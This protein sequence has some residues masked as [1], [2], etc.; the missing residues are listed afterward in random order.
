MIHLNS[1][2]TPRM[3]TSIIRHSLEQ[4]VGIILLLALMGIFWVSSVDAAQQLQ[5]DFTELSIE[6]LMNLD[7]DIVSGASKYAQKVTEAPSS[8][9]IVTADEIRKYGY[10]TLADILRSVRSFYTTY[11]RNYHYVGIRGFGRPGDYNVRLLLLLDGHRI[12]DNLDDSASIGT[13]FAIDVDLIDRVEVIRG[14]SSSLYGANAFF[15]VINIV[16]KRGQKLSGLETAAEAASFGKYKGRLSYGDKFRNGLEMILSGSIYD[17]KGQD[18]YFKEF[19]DPAT[20]NGVAENCDDDQYRSFF[21]RLSC[22]D[23][24]LQGGYVSREKGIP[25][26]S[27]ESE[28]NDPR[29]RTVDGQAYVSLKYKHR[30]NNQLAVMARL[31]YNHYNY[32]GDYVFDYSEDDVPYILVNK[33]VGRGKC[34]GGELKLTKNLM[35]KHRFVLGAEYRDNIQQDQSNYDEKVYLDDKR[36]A[37][38]WALYVQDEFQILHSLIFNAGLRYD[39]YDTFGGT[40][41][42]RLGLIYAPIEKTSLKLLYGQAF[43]APNVY[44]LYYDDGEDTQKANPDLEPE[45]IKTYEL[46]VEQYIGTHFRGSVAGF[47]YEIDDLIGQHTDPTDDLLV[48]KNLEEIEAKG[49]ELELEGKWDSGLK[50]RVS[51]TFQKAEDRQTGDVLSNSP[52]HL[53]KFSVGVPLIKEKLFAGMEAQY[54]STRRTL[55]D[56]D[57]D[58]FW[59]TNLTLSSTKLVKGLEVSASVY[60]LFDKRYGDPGSGEHLQDVIEQDGRSVR[61]QLTYGFRP[62][63]AY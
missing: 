23:F 50:G 6:E 57:A 26:A 47:Y 55:A 30:F 4:A 41:N 7:I 39:H 25:T 36:D 54:M 43:R 8:V 48:F 15:G 52:K 10:R 3:R 58:A 24:I 22:R 53:A 2:G 19:D 33:D 46:I 44:E 29:N 12:N 61:I 14:P 11:D 9:S 59:L 37:K 32:D 31:S 49:L 56:K 27:F 38:N 13:E 60:N 21:G 16:T 63:P 5:P 17:S 20:N 45:T 35:A 28:F 40:T 1:F 42:P 51:Y 62:D 18:L 34:W